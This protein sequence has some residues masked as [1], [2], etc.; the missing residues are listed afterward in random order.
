M[1]KRERERGK[2]DKKR[3][4]ESGRKRDIKHSNVYTITQMYHVPCGDNKI[5]RIHI[6]FHTCKNAIQL[7]QIAMV[8]LLLSFFS[9][10]SLLFMCCV[11]SWVSISVL[12]TSSELQN[13]AHIHAA[14]AAA[15]ANV[16]VEMDLM[17]KIKLSWHQMNM[18]LRLRA[19]S[20][21][22]LIKYG[23][24]KSK[25]FYVCSIYS[26]PHIMCLLHQTQTHTRWE[27]TT[28]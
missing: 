25:K 22:L 20:R 18:D 28:K 23:M 3:A 26:S 19:S 14:S 4:R 10:F 11:S 27:K 16:H 17:F 24:E 7:V 5:N 1:K 6:S 13:L 9:S 2:I 21:L 8:M 12:Q 15:A